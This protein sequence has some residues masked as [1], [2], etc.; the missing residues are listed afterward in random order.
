MSA[1][2][3]S[4]EMVNITREF[5]NVTII[6]REDGYWNA[7]A[8]C[9]ANGKEWS[10]YRLTD[11]ANAYAD[12]LSRSLGIPRDLLIQ[13]N[14]TGPNHLR[15]TW[16]HQRIAIHLAQWCNPRFAVMVTGW[17]EELLTKG[18]VE[19]PVARPIE[20]LSVATEF[21]KVAHTMLSLRGTMDLRDQLLLQEFARNRL[22]EDGSYE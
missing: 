2:S 3:G 10:N 21:L 7:T 11:G 1:C 12:A 8:M 6:Q 22:L 9:K 18:R 16:V 20:H 5:N 15:G 19:L 14:M 4:R 17:V 13:Q